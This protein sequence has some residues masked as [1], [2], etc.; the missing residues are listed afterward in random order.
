[1]TESIL[2]E[3]KDAVNVAEDDAAFDIQIKLYINSAFSTLNQL[4]IGP[5][6]GFRIAG[7]D[8]LW[9]EFVAEGPILDKVKEYISLKVRYSW[10]PPGT[11]FHTTAMKELVAEA[12][13][14]LS[15][16]REETDWV[17]P[18]PEEPIILDPFGDPILDP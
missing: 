15:Y 9:T 11:G 5:D 13:A 7:P 16:M 4:G 14:R 17:P 1:M 8:E 2:N 12:E 6:A 10:D 3:V 18:E